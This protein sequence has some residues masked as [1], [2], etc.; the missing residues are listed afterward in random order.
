MLSLQISLIRIFRA[1]AGYYAYIP[2]LLPNIMV[3]LGLCMIQYLWIAHYHLCLRHWYRYM[4][5]LSV[6][7]IAGQDNLPVYRWISLHLV[8]PSSLSV[9]WAVLLWT[10]ILLLRVSV[11]EWAGTEYWMLYYWAL[12]DHFLLIRLN[13]CHRN[14]PKN[15]NPVFFI[16]NPFAL[17]ITPWPNSWNTTTMNNAII[18]T[19]R[20]EYWASRYLYAGM[21]NDSVAGALG[22]N[23][24]LYN[25]LWAI[26]ILISCRW[27]LCLCLYSRLSSRTPYVFRQACRW[28]LCRNLSYI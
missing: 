18:H 22:T 6:G 5:C 4:L 21:T 12:L 10:T 23:I 14:G 7:R 11:E 20:D 25:L 2:F 3:S 1:D 19:E 28:T 17:A 13:E 24:R 26:H 9:G 27:I 8:W 15:P 16:F